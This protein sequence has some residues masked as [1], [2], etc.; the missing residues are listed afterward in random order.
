MGEDALGAAIR[1][2]RNAKG[3]RQQDLA[4]L[5]GVRQQSVGAW[6]TGQNVPDAPTLLALERHLGVRFGGD[7]PDAG[8]YAALQFARGEFTALA[9]VAEAMAA[10]ARAAADRLAAVTP[11]DASRLVATGTAAHAALDAVRA[12]RAPGGAAPKSRRRAGQ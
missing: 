5:L 9:G 2:A 11:P 6:E 12:G 4:D 8:S 3:L 10:Q 1:A 7:G